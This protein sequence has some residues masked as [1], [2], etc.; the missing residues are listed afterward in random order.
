MEGPSYGGL[1]G[2]ER[3]AFLESFGAGDGGTM[4]SKPDMQMGREEE[5]EEE[6]EKHGGG[7]GRRD[8]EYKGLE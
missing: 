7:I 8:E 1:L 6:E 4:G 5:K 2:R 3:H